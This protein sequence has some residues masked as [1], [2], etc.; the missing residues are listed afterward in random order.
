[1]EGSVLRVLAVGVNVV[2]VPGRTVPDGTI[3]GAGILVHAPIAPGRY[4]LEQAVH[5]VPF[6]QGEPPPKPIRRAGESER[7]SNSRWD[8]VRAGGGMR[9]GRS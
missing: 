6:D 5:Y 9:P 3:I 4:T 2:I 8:E 7:R 1:M